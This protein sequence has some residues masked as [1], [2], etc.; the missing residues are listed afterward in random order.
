MNCADVNVVHVAQAGWRQNKSGRIWA[1]VSGRKIKLLR[2]KKSLPEVRVYKRGHSP[3]LKEKSTVYEQR[4][5]SVPI[6]HH[7]DYRD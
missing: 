4:V 2:K 3:I 7:A 5:K 6:R 1:G